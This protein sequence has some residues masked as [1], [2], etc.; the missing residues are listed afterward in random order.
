MTTQPMEMAGMGAPVRVFRS[1]GLKGSLISLGF[2]LLVTV[3]FA[4]AAAVVKAGDSSSDVGA[5]CGL[6]GVGLLILLATAIGL[7]KAIRS[8]KTQFTLYQ[9]GLVKNDG[10]N[11]YSLRWADLSALWLQYATGRRGR[12]FLS[13]AILQTRQGGR[14]T[15]DLTDVSGSNQLLQTVQEKALEALFPHYLTAYNSGQ[16][17]QFGPVEISQMGLKLNNKSFAW[18]EVGGANIQ[19]GML[20]VQKKGGGWGSGAYAEISSIPNASVLLALIA[21]QT[22]AAT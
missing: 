19:G 2:G 7:P 9:D 21:A 11:E 1:G 16:T 22:G 14:V 3:G 15:V 18:S 6:S 17:L 5:L 4:V 12:R 10:T 13:Q 20:A 8:R